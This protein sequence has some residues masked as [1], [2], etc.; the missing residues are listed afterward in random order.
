MGFLSNDEKYFIK[1][2]GEGYLIK[3]KIIFVV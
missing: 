3:Y 2:Y 1:I